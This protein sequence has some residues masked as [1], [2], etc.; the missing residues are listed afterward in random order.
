VQ[1][2]THAD[3]GFGNYLNRTLFE[4]A[5]CEFGAA[6]SQAG[7]DHDWR[8]HFQHDF[9]NERQAVHARHFQVRDDNIG[10]FLLHLGPRNQR[11]GRRP[12]VNPVI[13]TQK[14]LHNLAD[15]RRIIHDEDL[16]VIS[17]HAGHV[18]SSS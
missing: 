3:L 1:E 10:R 13:G 5:Q 4:R 17:I 14:G 2:L 12:H 18:L 7:A 16:Q 11:V 9:S 6:C 8:R 15:H